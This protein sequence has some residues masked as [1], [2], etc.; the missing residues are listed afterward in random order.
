M[1]L[2]NF[3]QF[4]LSRTGLSQ[5]NGGGFNAAHGSA[6]SCDRTLCEAW[7][8]FFHYPGGYCISPNVSFKPLDCVCFEKDPE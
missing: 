4:K 2:L 7:C 5:V 6:G 1:F 8:R 3:D